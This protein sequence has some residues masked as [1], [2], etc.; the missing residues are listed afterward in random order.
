MKNETILDA[1]GMINE[2]AVLDAKAYQRPTSRSWM[3]W[4]AIAA[5]LC[6][7]IAGIFPLFNNQPGASPFVLT[8]YAVEIDGTLTPHAMKQNVSVPLGEIQLEEGFN[9]FLFSCPLEDQSELSAVTFLSAQSSPDLPTEEL[10][11][12][13]EEKGLQYFYYIPAEGESAP[14]SFNVNINK[15]NGDIYRY[16]IVID[17]SGSSFIATLTSQTV[18]YADGN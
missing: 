4:G 16:E 1:I 7:I 6:L 13:M 5:C 14:I 3:K 12:F 18:T 11:D 2:E 8:A 17:S 9:G 15:E 10:F